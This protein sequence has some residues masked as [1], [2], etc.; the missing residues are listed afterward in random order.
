MGTDRFRGGVR[1]DLAKN[2]TSGGAGGKEVR[3][4]GQD[5]AKLETDKNKSMGKGEKVMGARSTR[6]Q[7]S[8]SLSLKCVSLNYF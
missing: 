3:S 8:S 7:K 5:V 6:L 4:G 2:G 1:G